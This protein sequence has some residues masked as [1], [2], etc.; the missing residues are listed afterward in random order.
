M[1]PTVHDVAKF[2]LNQTGEISAMKL[3][4]LVYYS[5]AWSLVW[6]ENPLFSERIIAWANGPVVY[7]LYNEHR[8]QFTVS[9]LQP[10]NENQL[11]P[12][13]Q[14]TVSRVVD[15]YGKH[16]AQELSDFTHNEPPWKS[17]RKGLEPGQKGNVEISLAAMD[18]Y[19]SGI[20]G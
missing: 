15:F 5:Q 11:S 8:G 7:E 14:T 10:G 19:Y 12:E 20:Q 3:Q 17:A 18:E 1:M 6:D 2:I 9:V 4:K 13:Q 16:T